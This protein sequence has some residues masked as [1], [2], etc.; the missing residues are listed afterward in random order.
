MGVPLIVTA[1]DYGLTAGTSRAILQAHRTGIVTA[2][3]VLAV[4]S[5]AHASLT[6]LEDAPDLA[7]GVHLALVGEDPPV[8][9]AAEIPTLVD[10]RGRLPESWS[11]LVPRLAAGRI[12][13]ADIDREL[14]AQI[15]VVAGVR[16]IDHLDTHQHTHLWPTVAKVVVELARAHAVPRVR[17]PRPSS[18]GP[19]AMA[20]SRLAT[21]LECR[22]D[23]AGIGRTDRFAGLDE[24]GRWTR[25]GL[26]RALRR[27]ATAPG[28][29]EMNTHPGPGH[30]E[31]RARYQWDYG[32]SSELV[33]LTSPSIRQE[34]EACGFT[35][36][37]VLH[38][39]A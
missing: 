39:E 3:S 12:D 29:V 8:L 18:T 14:R 35:L 30:D 11:R 33:A 16:R 21:A 19:R 32:W 38:E 37:G 6:W 34:V 24:A 13:P 26:G 23:R 2:T 20:I 7:V 28:T 15:A 9:T 10:R 5:G 25:E 22:L 1:D 36:S 4:G 27:L 17:V 31:E